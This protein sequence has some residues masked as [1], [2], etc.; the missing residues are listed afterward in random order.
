MILITALC[1]KDQR[2]RFGTE[3]KEHFLQ[4]AY[5]LFRAADIEVLIKILD[6]SDER[7]VVDTPIA[8]PNDAFTREQLEVSFAQ[9]FRKFRIHDHIQARSIG[10]DQR[11]C[12][13]FFLLLQIAKDGQEWR[14]ACT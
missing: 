1:L 13:H 3:T 5:E 4:I 10:I 9:K 6:Q 7:I 11:V 2:I 8:E 12:L 14:D